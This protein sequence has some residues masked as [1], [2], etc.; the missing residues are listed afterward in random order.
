VHRDLKLENIF[1]EQVPGRVPRIKVLDFGLAKLTAPGNLK[2]T[3]W[4][5]T[6]G[7]PQYMSPEQLRSAADVDFGTDIWSLGVCLYEMLTC[8][9]PFEATSMP[10]LFLKILDEKHT[11]ILDRRAGIPA[12]IGTIIDRCLEKERAKRWASVE[13]LA[14]AL[15]PYARVDAAA[16]IPQS[17]WR[18]M[19]EAQRRPR[20]LLLLTALLLPPILVFGAVITYLVV[21][22]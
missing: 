6:M 8:S 11:P 22:R 1:L 17:Q 20:R 12:E 3:G 14:K 13:E 4:R 10:M 16:T 2:L 5:V 9:M 21:S 15:R 18:K 7:S 19:Q